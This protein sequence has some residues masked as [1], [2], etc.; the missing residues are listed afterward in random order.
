MTEVKTLSELNQQMRED[1]QNLTRALKGD[2]KTQGNWGELI[3][4]KRV[5]D[6]LN[7]DFM[8]GEAR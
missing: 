7:Q 6:Q 8:N 5:Q 2:S 1:A 4:E 3:L